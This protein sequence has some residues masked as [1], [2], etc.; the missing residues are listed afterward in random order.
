MKLITFMKS[1]PRSERDSF[2]A[3]CGTSWGYLKQ[4]AYGNKQC[5]EALAINIDRESG[6]LVTC[7]ELCPTADWAYIRSSAPA[8]KLIAQTVAA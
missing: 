2:A 6:R 8:E 1:V 5:G 3:R 7:E 4:V